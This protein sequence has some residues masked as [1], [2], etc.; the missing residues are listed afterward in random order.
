MGNIVVTLRM[1]RITVRQWSE[2]VPP[3][4]C[5]AALGREDADLH[6]V[7]PM[8][9]PTVLVCGPGSIVTA[10]PRSF[11]L[12]EL[13]LGIAGEGVGSFDSQAVG[14]PGGWVSR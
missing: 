14:G 12:F 5:G 13:S 11:T 1:L 6:V 9:A 3:E 2:G 7:S 10:R 8:I 4:R